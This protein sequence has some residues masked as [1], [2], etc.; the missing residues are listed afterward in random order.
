MSKRS[1]R[2]AAA[3]Y[4][5]GCLE[6]WSAYEK[7]VERWVGEAVDAGAEL[8]LFPE[9]FSMELASLFPP[10]VYRS[11]S[12]QLDSL[13][14]LQADFVGLYGAQARRHG[15]HILAG[16]FPVRQPDGNYRNR[17]LFPPA[18]REPGFPGQAADDPLRE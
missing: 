9:Y 13:Q 15:I 7:K 17:C 10:E 3:Q 16:S 2:L 18:G 6:N 4:D 12:G 1:F 14:T 5:I 11:L 8:L